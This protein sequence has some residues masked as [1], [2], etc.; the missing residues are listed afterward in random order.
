M[1]D[2]DVYINRF[3]KAKAY[4]RVRKEYQRIIPWDSLQSMLPYM[5]ECNYLRVLKKVFSSFKAVASI[6]VFRL[7]YEYEVLNEFHAP[8]INVYH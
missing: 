7:D 6:G 2:S 3:L 1:L 8:R 4:Q 5:T